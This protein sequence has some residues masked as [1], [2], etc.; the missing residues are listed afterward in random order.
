[1]KEYTY[2]FNKKAKLHLCCSNDELRPAM[3]NIYFDDG[4]AIATN[5]HILICAD[6][7]ECSNLTDEDIEKLNGKLLN[8]ASYKEMLKYPKICI[9]DAGIEATRPIGIYGSTSTSFEFTED[10]TYPNYKSVLDNITVPEDK[11]EQVPN[12][13]KV[14]F[15][16]TSLKK[17]ADAVGIDLLYLKFYSKEGAVKVFFDSD[18]M[19]NTKAIIMPLIP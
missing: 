5:G 9:T 10:T 13:F 6:L 15:N 16:I 1:M 7:H 12:I 3:N 14:G 4:H 11:D 8:S 19:T 17:I 2:N 18:E